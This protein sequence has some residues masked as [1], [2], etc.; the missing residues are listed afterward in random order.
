MR[1]LS[2]VWQVLDYCACRNL[3][4]QFEFKHF[5]DKFELIKRLE[6]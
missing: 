1:S 3:I 4:L 5:R 6:S 2:L